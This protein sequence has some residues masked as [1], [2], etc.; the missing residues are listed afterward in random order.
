MSPVNGSGQGNPVH[1]YKVVVAKSQVIGDYNLRDVYRGHDCP[2]PE[3]SIVKPWCSIVL[4]S[5]ARG[6]C[7]SREDSH[8]CS[9]RTENGESDKFV[10][11]G[12]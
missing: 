1:G 10:G 11:D 12:C 5:D 2:G 9:I 3:I 6:V 8:D 7:W 4:V